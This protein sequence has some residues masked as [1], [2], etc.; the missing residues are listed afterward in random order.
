MASS[1]HQSVIYW[2]ALLYKDLFYIPVSQTDEPL[3]SWSLCHTQEKQIIYKLVIRIFADLHERP[4]EERQNDVTEKIFVCM[5]VF[6]EN[7]NLRKGHSGMSSFK[8]D[9]LTETR[10]VRSSQSWETPK[11][12]HL[13]SRSS[14]C[15]SPKIIKNWVIQESER[16]IESF[17][18]IGGRHRRP[19]HVSL[20][21]HG[22]ESWV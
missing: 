18:R 21:A 10:N 20:S 16:R 15:Q 12:K 7:A 19:D 11:D 1:F 9:L 13:T 3:P 4:A 2:A 22:S 8:D 14:M 5:C 6:G 17:V